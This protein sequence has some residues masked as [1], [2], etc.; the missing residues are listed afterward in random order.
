MS[1]IL[2]ALRKVERERQQPEV[3]GIRLVHAPERSSRHRWLILILVILVLVNLAWFA[4]NF[5]SRQAIESG[6]APAKPGKEIEI[7]KTGQA[8][9]SAILQSDINKPDNQKTAS[10]LSAGKTTDQKQLTYAPQSITDLVANDNHQAKPIIPEQSKQAPANQSRVKKQLPAKTAK[11]T[12]KPQ[13]A[14]INSAPTRTTINSGKTLYPKHKQSKQTTAREESLNKPDPVIKQS[15]AQS[16]EKRDSATNIPMLQQLSADF[17]EQLPQLKINVYV[18][19]ENAD[20]AF[21]IINMRK[22]QIGDSI[23]HNL[24][25]VDIGVDSITLSKDG[26]QFRVARP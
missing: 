22:F 16:T 24:K 15:S 8:K 7:S 12:L 25:L 19:A 9:P 20:K 1:Y 3:P 11:G 21:V 13:Q 6:L 14:S 2:D 5:I 10:L 26:K 4:Y 23:E 18:Y 17:R